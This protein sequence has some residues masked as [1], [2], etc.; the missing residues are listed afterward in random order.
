MLDNIV[1]KRFPKLAPTRWN[2]SSRLVETVKENKD[3]IMDLLRNILEIPTKFDEKTKTSAGGLLAALDTFDFNFLLHVFSSIFPLTEFLFSVLQTKSMDIVHCSFIV[4]STMKKITQ[5]RD[6]KFEEMWNFVTENYGEPVCKRKQTLSPKEKY[7]QLFHEIFDNILLQM[8]ARFSSMEKL[9][10]IE[11]LDC[12]K[13]Q[14]YDVTFPA[15]AFESLKRSYSSFFQFS[16]L[17][18]ELTVLYSH[19]HFCKKKCC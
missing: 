18:S 7:S 9:E 12:S 2:Y 5:M 4:E 13:F 14:L 11:L 16:R 8:K 10:F 6:T 15:K 3:D 1:G 19:K 17:H